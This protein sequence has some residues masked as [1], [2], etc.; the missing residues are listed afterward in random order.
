MSHIID[1]HSHILPGADDGSKTL[2]ESIA[3]LQL[4]AEQGISTVVATP[5]FYAGT[6]TP[7]RFLQR[8]T[9]A[10]RQLREEME[11]YNGLPE[12]Y[13]GAEVHYFSGISE[14]TSLSDFTIGETNYI[15][16]EMP[17]PP[18]TERMYKELEAIHIKRNLIPVI[19]HIDRYINPFRQ[20]G[21]PKRLQQMPVVV[22]ANADFFLRPPTS[23]MAL[24]MLQKGQIQLL[25]SDCHNLTSRPPNLGEAIEGIKKRLG[26]EYV[27]YIC[28]N[29]RVILNN[30]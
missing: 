21:I 10:E 26:S 23:L 25:G 11:K 12:L 5:H 4:E 3:M 6:D 29:G 9:L 2:E 17:C 8:R 14:S 15:M 28:E 20:Y 27:D 30:I 7:E 1:F 13:V 22:Q 19:A 16:I 24:R 18:W